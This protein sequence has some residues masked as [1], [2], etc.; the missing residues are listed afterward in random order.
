MPITTRWPSAFALI[1]AVAVFAA[2]CSYFEPVYSG[3]GPSVVIFSHDIS[4]VK[5]AILAQTAIEHFKPD[6]DAGEH[7]WVA[8]PLSA[9]KVFASTETIRSK[10]DLEIEQFHIEATDAGIRVY[11]GRVEQLE[12]PGGGYNQDPL[13]DKDQYMALKA[14]LDAVKRQ[15]EGT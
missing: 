2:G 5:A 10:N 13:M 4:R 12:L 8:R 14:L 15:V 9:L 7:L 3:D 11:V 6:G 1:L